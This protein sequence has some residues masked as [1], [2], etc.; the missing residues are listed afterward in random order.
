VTPKP[1]NKKIGLILVLII[2][3]GGFL[4][5]IIA[6][7]LSQKDTSPINYNAN[8]SKNNNN[9]GTSSPYSF[10][11]ANSY[12][13]ASPLPDAFDR[14]YRGTIGDGI[15]LTMSLKRDGDELTGRAST[16]SIDYLYGS[17]DDDGSF[18]LDGKKDDKV[19]TGTYTGHIY[20]DG[21]IRGTWTKLNSKKGTSASFSLRLS[22]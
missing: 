7:S 9:S 12:N 20:S 2:F 19:S 8:S 5:I 22:E 17:I 21:S 3:G 15:P 14:V 6:R 10:N 1:T 16:T 4:C 18:S 11:T 13:S